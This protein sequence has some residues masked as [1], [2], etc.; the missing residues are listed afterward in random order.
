MKMDLGIEARVG[1]LPV[2]HKISVLVSAI[3]GSKGKHLSIDFA[4][5]LSMRHAPLGNLM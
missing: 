4:V 5:R 2:H 1:L 3:I